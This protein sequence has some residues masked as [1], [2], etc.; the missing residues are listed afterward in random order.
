M[1]QKLY[2][3]FLAAAFSLLTVNAWADDYEIATAQDLADFAAT[4]NGGETDANAVLTADIDMSS[5]T[6]WT[7]IGI[8]NNFGYK[9]TFDGQG[10][11]ITGFQLTSSTTNNS[12]G[13]GFFGHVADGA[14]IKNFTIY[15]TITSTGQRMSVIGSAQGNVNISGI[16]SHLNIT[17]TQTRHGGI[18]GAQV[19][20]GTINI[21]RCSFS[22][23]LTTDNISGNFGG[24][25]G[26]TLNNANAYINITNCLFDGTIDIGTGDNAGGF[27]GYTRSC[28]L[29]IENCLSVGTITATN[30]GQFI[31][32]INT[33]S[34]QKYSG[35]N[36]YLGDNKTQG[37]GTATEAGT[38]PVKVTA[39]QL[40]S[41]EIAF[42]LN[43]DQSEI[44]WYLALKNTVFT[45]QQYVVT[46]NGTKRDPQN[47]NTILTENDRGSYDF[48]L[49]DFVV[50]TNSTD[51]PVGDV[52]LE[53]ITIE[54]DGTFSKTGTFNV[55]D[56]NIPS[57]MAAFKS[58]LQNIP[59]TL[60]GKVNGDKLYANIND[61][62]VTLPVLGAYAISVEVG[63]DNFEAKAPTGDAYPAPQGTA[64]VYA[65]GSFNC[66]MTPK[67]GSTVIYSNTDASIIDA[68]S[69]ADGFCTVCGALDENY[70]AANAEGFFEIANEKQLV[71]FAAYVNQV[72]ASVN[73]LLVDDIDMTG[74]AW[75]NPIGN[76]V[77]GAYYS[78]HFDGQGFTITGLSY[79]TNQ[80]NH[81]LFGRLAAGATVENFTIYGTINNVS[82]DAV[83]V[84]GYTFGTTI[85]ILGITSYLNLTN[86]G[87]DKKVGGILGNGNQGTTNVD[88]CSFFG[89]IET[90][91]KANCGGIAGYIQNNS[92]T[93]INFSNCLYAGSI[94]TDVTNAY[95]GGIVGYIGA[96]SSVYTVKNCLALGTVDAPVAGSIFGYV[97][98]KGAGSS[99]NYILDGTQTHGKVADNCS[100][101]DNL[102]TSVTTEQLASGEVAYKLGAAWSQLLG[103]DN[104]PMPTGI[105]PVSYVGEAGY[106]TL[107]DTTTG[108]E[109]N[110][111]VKAYVAVL[112]S[113]WLDLSEIDN[114]PAGT[115]VVLKGGYYNKQAADLPAINVANDLKGTDTATAADGTMYVL[116][117]GSD[118]I[119][120][121]KAEGT[122]P[123]GKAYYQSTS[124]AKA[125]FFTADDAT[126]IV[127]SL[128]ETKE[129]APVFNLAGQRIQKMQRGINIVGSKKILY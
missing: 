15:G 72:D 6:G 64:V 104:T 128:G 5:L 49:P 77:D 9:G 16:H 108:Y 34:N 123:A 8:D 73:A 37:T 80:N 103:T 11:T 89:T 51:I 127:S 100:T 121:Y 98:N 62:N 78:G 45:A 48:I 18:L 25:V 71:W 13:A 38:T 82:Y 88:R 114:I 26:L 119:G 12:Y 23:S 111:D 126:G 117:N 29:K 39:E 66:D 56:E 106:A 107:Y 3:L 83:A 59:Y 109:L 102:A 68:H 69:F 65:N 85:N 47:A 4:V 53:D 101:T 105:Y 95:C 112:N 46:A 115:P 99:N 22:G 110:G 86:S 81:G 116:A 113:T 24:I 120:F 30:P 97:R 75:P 84:V 55:P 61:I 42:K 125:F 40:A 50:H 31:G 58:Y 21:D 7:P 1:K 35:T 52:V 28:Q 33:T 87:N 43:G 57:S 91:D 32:Q 63:T 129:G 44:N 17:C 10:K 67:E 70:I 118:G 94:T 74:I 2:S 14:N 90:T 19:G 20:N 36:Y 27:V 79:T 41:G 54:D 76:S 96:N 93:K 124:G 92:S 122:I 60:S